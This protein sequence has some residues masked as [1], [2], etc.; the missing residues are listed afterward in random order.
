[1]ALGNMSTMLEERQF[2]KQGEQVLSERAFNLVIGGMLIWGF[3]LNYLM[4]VL[5]SNSINRLL[6][7]AGIFGFLIGYFALVLLG[8]YLI[9]RRKPALGFIGYNLIAVPVGVVVCGC[10]QGVPSSIVKTVVLL[11]AIVSLSIMIV[12]T[13]FPDFFLRMGRVLGFA[14]LVSLLAEMV[15]VFLFHHDAIIYEWIFVALFSMFIGYDWARANTCARTLD[16]AI[17]L[18]ALLYLDIVN[19][20]L[21]ILSMMSK[22]KK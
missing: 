4:V 15:S 21:R 13:I 7:S 14:L 18:S 16:N 1:M 3:G 19:I 17:S 22:R 10:V 6:N 12:A 11:T 5:F 9:T 2:A 20:F 8:N